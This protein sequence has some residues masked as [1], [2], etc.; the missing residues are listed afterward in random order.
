M[1]DPDSIFLTNQ[2]VCASYEAER[3]AQSVR[4]AA[5]SVG[6]GMVLYISSQLP[7]DRSVL[8]TT[9]YGLGLACAA[10][11]L[12]LWSRVRSVLGTGAE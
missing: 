2:G 11:N 7:D 9:G 1:V 5:G 3:V 4:L 10:W 12:Y 6:A 8:R